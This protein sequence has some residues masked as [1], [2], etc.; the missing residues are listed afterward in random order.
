MSYLIEAGI[1]P[2]RMGAN[3]DQI[4]ALANKVLDSPI[5]VPQSPPTFSREIDWL[6]QRFGLL[7]FM[8]PVVQAALAIRSGE[9]TSL[10]D[11]L[12]ARL[13]VA[14]LEARAAEIGRQQAELFGLPQ[15]RPDQVDAF[16]GVIK[17]ADTL[18]A[19]HEQLLRSAQEDGRRTTEALFFMQNLVFWLYEKVLA[20]LTKLLAEQAT[21][22]S[23][24]VELQLSNPYTI[25]ERNHQVVYPQIRHRLDLITIEVRDLEAYLNFLSDLSVELKMAASIPEYALGLQL[26]RPSIVGGV[27]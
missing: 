19:N 18:S 1:R 26:A 27:Q 22:K 10:T 13:Q 23:T 17:V 6:K 16:S 15:L 7:R 3:T 12:L 9:F 20:M 14:C 21:L 4:V 24:E 11:S 25:V 2:A 5:V 8:P